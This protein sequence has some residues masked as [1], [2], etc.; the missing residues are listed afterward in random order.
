[1][2]HSHAAIDAQALGMAQVQFSRKNKIFA[3]KSLRKKRAERDWD[4]HY[5]PS[6]AEP[7]PIDSSWPGVCRRP[8]YLA[9]RGGDQ[10]GWFH[11]AT[12][13]PNSPS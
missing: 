3:K 8:V 1:L 11:L 6:M 13:T 9:E 5:S 2:P 10:C 12:P 7:E 4:I